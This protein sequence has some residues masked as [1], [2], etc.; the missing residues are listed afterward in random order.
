[1]NIPI[2]NALFDMVARP[3]INQIARVFQVRELQELL[4]IEAATMI[5]NSSN[6]GLLEIWK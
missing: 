3:L 2:Q 5:L 6:K 1:M 4:L